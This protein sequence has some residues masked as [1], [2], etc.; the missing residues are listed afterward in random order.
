VED[1]ITMEQV[2][3]GLPRESW[4]ERTADATMAETIHRRHQ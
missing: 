3:L 1:C 4:D 2:D